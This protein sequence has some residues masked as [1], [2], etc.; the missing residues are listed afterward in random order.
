VRWGLPAEWHFDSW[1]AQNA[2]LI[3]MGTS[4]QETVSTAGCWGRVAERVL[5]GES[6]TG[7][8]R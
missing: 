1:R 6:R 8:D 7:P 5:E 3:V 4:R 2:N